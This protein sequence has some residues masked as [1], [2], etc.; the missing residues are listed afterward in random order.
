MIPHL[1]RPSCIPPGDGRENDSIG[2]RHMLTRPQTGGAFYLFEFWFDPESGNSLHVHE[3][4]DETVYVLEGAIRIR[5]GDQTLETTAGG[6]A[7]L[8]RAIP[9]ALYNPLSTASRYLALAIP[10]GMEDFFDEMAAARDAGTLDRPTHR[11][12]SLKYGITWLE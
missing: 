8:P 2:F 9:H 4:E 12:I 1:P 11:A 3:R 6:V 10:G 7:H 5:V